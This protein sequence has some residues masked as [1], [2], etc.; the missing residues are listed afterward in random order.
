MVTH[1]ANSAVGI[2]LPRLNPRVLESFRV[3]LPPIEEQ[4]RIAAVLDTADALRAKRRKVLAKLDSLT[5]AVFFDMFGSESFELV[6]LADLA[7][8]KYGTSEKAAPAGLATLRIPNVVRGE[9]SY[10]DI[11][12][13][14]VSVEELSRLR[15]SDGDLLFV[16][17]N[18]NPQYVGKCAVFSQIQADQSCFAEPIIYA[19]YLIR[20][21]L[22]QDRIRSIFACAFLNGPLGRRA[23]R[24]KCRTS[25]GQY[26]LNTKGLG[27]VLLPLPP[28]PMQ[29]AFSE[30][31]A[32]VKGRREACQEQLAHFDALRASLQRRAFR[33]EL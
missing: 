22:R 12:R 26:N 2:N 21:R 25:A 13:V 11:K 29:D 27:S 30:R 10:E 9:V 28:V 24:S 31:M 33:G 18:G 4:R 15:L 17:S 7:D 5:Q 8:F 14:P 3:P 32:W 23:L 16:R 6:P 19:S 20:A 1:A